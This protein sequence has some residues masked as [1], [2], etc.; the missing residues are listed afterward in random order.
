MTITDDFSTKQWT[1][2]DHY[3]I[4]SYEVDAAGKASLPTICKFMQETAYNHA[5][6][7]NFGYVHLKERNQFWVLSRLLITIDRY[8]RWGETIRLQTWPS[9]VE[10]LIAYRDFRVSDEQGEIIGAAGSAWLVLDI[11][12]RRLQKP[13]VLKGLSHLYPTERALDRR[14]AKIKPLSEAQEG[15]FVPVRYSDLDLY[16]H[17]NNAKYIQ[18]IFDGFEADLHRQ[19]EARSLE[20]NFVAEAKLGDE[21]AVHTKKLKASSHGPAFRH[22]IRR[23][24]DKKDIC[25]AETKWRKPGS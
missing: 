8:P 7:L 12:E 3:L 5:N 18:W 25:L 1:W 4:S 24:A 10:G 9:G 16:N 13:E 14:P 20:V 17:V 15:P 23:K 19:Y 22:S 21:T 11:E 6:H 2:T